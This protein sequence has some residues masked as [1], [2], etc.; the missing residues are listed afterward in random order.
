LSSGAAC[1]RKSAGIPHQHTRWRPGL[2]QQRTLCSMLHRTP[3][4][5]TCAPFYLAKK[6]SHAFAGIF[7][8]HYP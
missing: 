7:H 6:P 5:T 8:K 1:D 2:Q 4:R 3:E